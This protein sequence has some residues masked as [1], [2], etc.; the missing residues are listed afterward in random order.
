MEDLAFNMSNKWKCPK[1]KISNENRAS[2]CAFCGA[3]QPSLNDS[4]QRKEEELKKQHEEMM[5]TL[6]RLINP[7]HINQKK[8]LLRMIEDAF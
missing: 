2:K 4:K 3:E 7:L 5:K 1:C 8:R 6:F